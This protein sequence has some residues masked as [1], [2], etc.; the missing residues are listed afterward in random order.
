MAERYR[1]LLLFG[2]PGV[3]K[4][5]QG[6]LLGRIP[7]FRH[8]STGDMFRRLDEGSEL[9]RLFADFSARGDLVPDD[10][11][12]RAWEQEVNRLIEA[13]EYNPAKDILV[14]DGIPRSVNQCQI[15]ASK[16]DVQ[17][18]VHLTCADPEVMYERLR[19]RALKQGRTDDAREE[20]VK[21]RWEV[22][23][24]DTAPVL[25]FYDPSL[26]R[27]IE[28]EGHPAR[29]LWRLLGEAAPLVEG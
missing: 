7:S 17:L 11:T 4:G 21:H 18:I 15:M 16:I 22:Y 10:L 20:V 5:T 26:V 3:G 12:I 13:G 27:E 28:A 14:L 8:I 6:S 29:V 23:L 2:G 1:S 25:G 19:R 24:D 9:G